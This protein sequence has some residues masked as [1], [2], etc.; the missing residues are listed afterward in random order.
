MLNLLPIQPPEPPAQHEALVTL[1]G[2]RTRLEKCPNDRKGNWHEA[3]TR[4]WADMLQFEHMVSQ[5]LAISA[6]APS[7]DAS[8]AI[9]YALDQLVEAAGTLTNEVER[10]AE[11]GAANGAFYRAIDAANARRDF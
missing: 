10:K 8:E 1:A 11:D 4:A 3:A 7:Q 9:D 2:Y 6:A 5:L